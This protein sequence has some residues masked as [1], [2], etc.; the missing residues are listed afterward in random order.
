M[1]MPI[2]RRGSVS[3][4]F[5]S[6]LASVL[7]LLISMFVLQNAQASPV[8]LDEVQAMAQAWA[9][10]RGGIAGEAREAFSLQAVPSTAAAP[11]FYIASRGSG[12]WL[13]LSADD[14]VQPVIGYSDEPLPAGELPFALVNWLQ[15]E[16][17]QLLEKRDSGANGARLKAWDGLFDADSEQDAGPPITAENDIPPLLQA[18]WGQGSPCNGSCPADPAGSGGHAYVGCVAVALAQVM[19]YWNWPLQGQYVQS[20]YH[21]VYGEITVDFNQASYNWELITPNSCSLPVQELLYHAGVAVRMNYGPSGSSAQTSMIVTALRSYFRYQDAVRMVWRSSYE[22]AAWSSLIAGELR[23]GRPVIYRGQGPQGGHA[24]NVDGLQD[25]NWFHVNWGWGGS[26][27]G[28][29]LLEDLTPGNYYFGD[30][31]GAV[32]GIAPPGYPVNHAPIVTS[33]YI[34]GIEDTELTLNLLGYDVDGDV[35]RF[36]VEGE[37]LEGN[38]WSW[39][40][41]ANV[42]GTILL[43]YYACDEHEMCGS[44]APIVLQIA[45]AN[46][47]PLVQP[48]IYKGNEDEAVNLVLTGSDLEGDSLTFKVNGRTLSGNA[49]HWSPPIDANGT[50]TFQYQACDSSVCSQPAALVVYL[51]AV[52]DPPMVQPKPS[53]LS[54]GLQHLP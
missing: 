1:E 47:A 29:F 43:H 42:N 24:Y 51:K 40:P 34:N 14:E 22:A 44:T 13:V 46:D 53:R 39:T 8:S 6:H 11:V 30:V 49:W 3:K 48:R 27:N 2:F 50:F 32:V 28:W 10:H 36:V 33:A 38:V 37:P 25:N 19:D 15:G 5:L 26:Y 7:V 9:A 41:P 23:E 20:Y 18:V 4:Y 54:E 35:L 45:P 12:G 31:Q 17:L 16:E 21:D 52:D